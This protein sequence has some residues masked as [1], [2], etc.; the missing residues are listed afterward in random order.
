MGH[1]EERER[2]EAGFE[3]GYINEADPSVLRFLIA[4]RRDSFLCTCTD[5]MPTCT[6]RSFPQAADD[7]LL[8]NIC[9]NCLINVT[10]NQILQDT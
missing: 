6:S 3:E 7:S 4:S 1:A 10:K 2:G 9:I 8:Y 5:S